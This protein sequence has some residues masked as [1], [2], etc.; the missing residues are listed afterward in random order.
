[1]PMSFKVSV[2]NNAGNPKGR[3][4]LGTVCQD[5]V[6]GCITWNEHNHPKFVKYFLL[7]RR[8][9]KKIFWYNSQDVISHIYTHT[10]AHNKTFFHGVIEN[11]C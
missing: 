4:C 6:T 11:N 1:M 5:V 7:K 9:N 3:G 10:R 2:V 8:I